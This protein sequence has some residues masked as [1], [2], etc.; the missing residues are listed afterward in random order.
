MF[1]ECYQQPLCDDIDQTNFTF[2]GLGTRLFVHC[3][4]YRT[5]YVEAYLVEIYLDADIHLDV[6]Y[7]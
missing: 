3:E 4:R 5:Y 7:C 2:M 6:I 1:P